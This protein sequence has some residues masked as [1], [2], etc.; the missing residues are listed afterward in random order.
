MEIKEA[1]LSRRLEFKPKYAMADY[2]LASMNDFKYHYS[3][4]LIL[5]CMFH[6]KFFHKSQKKMCK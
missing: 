3:S 5:T 2:E 1:A 4:I 6:K